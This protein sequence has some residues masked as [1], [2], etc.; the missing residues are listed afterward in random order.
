MLRMIF[1]FGAAAGL[2]VT[3]P[4]DLLLS[5]GGPGSA[6]SSQLAGYLIMILALS[7]IFVGVK[8][9]RDRV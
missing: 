6:A 2:I 9:Y 7:L 4:M 8:R 3:V 5:I 1:A